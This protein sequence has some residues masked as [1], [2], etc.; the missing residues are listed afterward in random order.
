MSSLTTFK[1]LVLAAG[2][3]GALSLAGCSATA[4]Y[5]RSPEDREGGI[6]GTGITVDCSN[7]SNQDEPECQAQPTAGQSK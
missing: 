3:A 5:P 7:P 2:M 6:S 1:S 4:T